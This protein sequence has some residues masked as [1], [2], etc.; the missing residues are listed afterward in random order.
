MKWHIL[1]STDSIGMFG[2]IKNLNK[3]W[4][5]E[6]FP[7]VE[8]IS[9]RGREE[10]IISQLTAH[11]YRIAHLHGRM[12]N[13]IPAMRLL[14]QLITRTPSLMR[15]WGTAYDI[16]IHTSEARK[17]TVINAA[18]RATRIKRI[19]I[20]ND[21][22]GADGVSRMRHTAQQYLHNGIPTG[23]VF[24]V[25]H[26]IRSY[27]ESDLLLR[28]SWEDMM[29]LLIQLKPFALG[30]HF[31]IGTRVDDSLPLDRISDEM[32]QRFAGVCEYTGVE[33]ITL[34]YQHEPWKYRAGSIPSSAFPVIRTRIERITNRLIK[35]NLL[36]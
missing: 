13:D 11:G 3:L 36:V 12:G 8:M 21:E 24:D 34:E 32:L 7:Y 35:N 30:I 29:P 15:R 28:Q 5:P 6:R 23:V 9:W 18:K 31:P 14:D 22:S 26:Y 33:R 1:V 20:E 10:S 25:F 2:D 16:L 27:C 17:A 4:T 19:W